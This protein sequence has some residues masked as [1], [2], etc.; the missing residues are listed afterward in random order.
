[1]RKYF[2]LILLCITLYSFGTTLISE[3]KKSYTT[4]K[5]EGSSPVIDGLMNDEAWDLIEWSDGFKQTEPYEN[6]EPSQQTKF[7][8]LYDDNNLY[9]LVRAYDSSPDSI[10]KRLSRR[11]EL[12]TREPG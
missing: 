11:D 5:I 1:M 12:E 3:P 6:I 10:V 2:V 4:K 9:V 7:K 8:I